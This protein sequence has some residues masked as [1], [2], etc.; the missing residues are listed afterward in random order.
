MSLI[1]AFTAAFALLLLVALASRAHAPERTVTPALALVLLGLPLADALLRTIGLPLIFT[2]AGY[3][4]LPLALWWLIKAPERLPL[5]GLAAFGVALAGFLLLRGLATAFDSFGENIFSLRY[6]QSLRL[7][8]TYPAP[9]LWEAT[10]T[11]ANYYTAIHNLPALLSRAFALPVPFAISLSLAAL[12]AAIWTAF[13]E[14]FRARAGVPL[15]AG[16]A[17]VVVFAGSGVS[18]WLIQNPLAHNPV[19][20]GWPHVRLFGMRP[21][22]FGSSFLRRLAE[23]NPDLPLEP[24]L[25]PALYLGD[26]H[27]PLWTFLLAALLVFAV[28]RRGLPGG[29]IRL[30]AFL[31]ALPWLTWAGNPWLLPHFGLLA[32]TMVALDPRLRAQW[33]W[34]L[35]AGL[36]G[37][38]LLWPLILSADYRGGLVSFAWLPSVGR[39]TPTAWL[40]VWAPLLALALAALLRRDRLAWLLGLVLLLI[41]SMEVV[42]FSQGDTQS[43]FARFNGTLK[44]WSALHL[45]GIGLGL[46]ALMGLQGRQRWLW[47]L[48]L[49]LVMASAV[50]GRDVVLAQVKK[51][52]PRFDWSSAAKL[53]A[54][55]DRAMNL[56][57]LSALPQG[58]TMERMGRSA[59]D[60]A[61]LTS[62]LAG[63]FTVSGWA[64]HAAQASGDPD[65][66][67]RRY[68]RIRDWYDRAG[69]DALG[70]LREWQV[71][72]VL[73][74]WDAGWSAERLAT[75][76]S[77]LEPDYHFLPGREGGG[78]VQ[79]GLFIRRQR[80]Q[81]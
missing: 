14:A 56:M 21:D 72:Y 81:P 39:A 37:W 76:R 13:F 75:V 30:A 47:G 18:L 16:G 40:V 4:V 41:L 32:L 42:L 28:A 36:A 25:H 38:A 2:G 3:V 52:Q 17:S 7:A 8:S 12:L 45:L 33:R 34:A 46:L 67:N 29:E 74:D 73:L 58:R 1:F 69:A 19:M 23:T 79:S 68:E 71:D 78:G 10:P 61:P 24:P 57:R 11:I 27:P 60:L 70:L 9:D 49:P 53:T 62:L 22:E 5:A 65:R 6:V 15:S 20:L 48:A 44:V 77:A 64:H 26:L 59:Y 54:R 63:H 66:E 80:S 50:H 55:E 35:G 51:G 31:G 43:A